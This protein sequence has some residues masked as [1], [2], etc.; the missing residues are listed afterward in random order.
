MCN[1]CIYTHIYMCISLYTYLYDI[2]GAG[3]AGQG[4]IALYDLAERSC[5]SFEL[6]RTISDL[7][8]SPSVL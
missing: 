7:I 2:W 5:S 4:A 3:E 8:Q 6:R 1:D